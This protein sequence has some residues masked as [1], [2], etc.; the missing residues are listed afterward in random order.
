MT[1]ERHGWDHS[2]ESA[3]RFVKGTGFRACPE[4][5]RMGTAFRWCCRHQS[6]GAGCPILRIAKGGMQ[7]FAA[8]LLACHSAAQRRN[9]LFIPCHH[10]IVIVAIRAKARTAVLW[11]R[12]Y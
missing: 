10:D 1:L 7:P 12:L 11:A 5:S 2:R 3:N 9:L 8:L 6:P 4:R